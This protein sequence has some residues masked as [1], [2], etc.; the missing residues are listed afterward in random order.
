MLLPLYITIK[1]VHIKTKSLAVPER[2]KTNKNFLFKQHFRSFR[3]SKIRKGRKTCQTFHSLELYIIYELLV[4]RILHALWTGRKE[5][6]KKEERKQGW[7]SASFFFPF[8]INTWH[9]NS[10]DST[11]GIFDPQKFRC[12][13]SFFFLTMINMGT[14]ITCVKTFLIRMKRITELY[15]CDRMKVEKV[16]K[17]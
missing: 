2:G 5:K 7:I 11:H 12:Y 10:K 14:F 4:W 13:P 8:I 3:S 1:Y 16:N 9:S 6:R 17:L 15:R